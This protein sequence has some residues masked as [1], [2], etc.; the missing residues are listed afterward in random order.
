MKLQMSGI[1]MHFI[2]FISVDW[3]FL[4]DVPKVCMVSK[5]FNGLHGFRSFLCEGQ[6]DYFQRLSIVSEV[7]REGDLSRN[8]EV[9]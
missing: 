4:H 5:V 3:L 6:P 8:R 7:F 1:Q 9:T 2:C